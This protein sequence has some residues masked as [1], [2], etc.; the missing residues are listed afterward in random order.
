MI[1]K[2]CNGCNKYLPIYKNETVDGIRYRLCKYCAT[3]KTIKLK[4]NAHQ[5]KKRSEKKKIEDRVYT[6]L[7]KKYLKDHE[8]CEINSASCTSVATEVHHTAYR[9]GTNYL[10]T[11]TWKASCRACHKWIHSNPK[12]ARDLGFLI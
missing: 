6:I 5:I 10:D 3:A 11:D 4:P 9:T 8:R 2:Q 12:E 1:L 7:N